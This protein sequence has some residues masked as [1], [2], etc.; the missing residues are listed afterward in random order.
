M[1]ARIQILVA[2]QSDCVLNS[3]HALSEELACSLAERVVQGPDNRRGG[4]VF[5]DTQA[6]AKEGNV[7]FL[8]D[9]FVGYKHLRTAI[10]ALHMKIPELVRRII[11]I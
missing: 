6:A 5:A 2:E 9:G 1:A 3:R 8:S 10:G 11:T 4:D 7:A